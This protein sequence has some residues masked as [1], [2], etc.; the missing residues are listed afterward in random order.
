MPA[1]MHKNRGLSLIELMVG[2][3]IGM[4]AIIIIMQVAITF[5]GQKRT[6]VGTAGA[7]DE[8]AVG[9]FTL[10]KEIQ[11]AGYGMADPDLLACLVQAHEARFDNLA[12]AADFSF[13]IFPVLITQG[14]SGAPDS[15][16][17]NYS[18]SPMLATAASLIQNFP[19][20]ETTNLKLNNRYGFNAGDVVILA[21]PTVLAPSPPSPAGTRQ[22]SMY[23]V[24]ALPAA[25]GETD[26]VKHELTQYVNSA[27]ATVPSRF[28]KSGGLGIA[29]PAN[30]T[31]IFNLGGNP[32]SSVFSIVN[33]QLV[34]QDQLTGSP[35]PLVLLDNVISFQAQYGFD[36]RPGAQVNLQVTQFS[37]TVIDADGSG[38]AGNSDDWM[39]LGAVRVAIVV[40][41]KYPE[42][43]DATTGLCNTTTNVPAWTWG[44]IPEAVLDPADTDEWKCYRYKVFESVIPL[45]NMFW[46]AAS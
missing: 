28:N 15:I 21:N 41:N 11:S 46:K 13:S 14:V 44:S 39:R 4:I 7:M 23:Q 37:D 9:L 38:V 40:R 33:N 22:C 25:A 18:S 17:V 42:R 27:G 5:E 31:K 26:E 29:Y 35:T 20:D 34:F 24:T 30:T 32:V 2:V 8:G 45:R 3:V 6:T 10:R 16:T 19:G 43:P 36:M 12:T 1:L